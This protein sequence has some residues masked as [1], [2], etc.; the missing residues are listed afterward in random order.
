M[1]KFNLVLMSIIA[2]GLNLSLNAKPNPKSPLERTLVKSQKIAQRDALA[3][4]EAD[5]LI[6]Q[7]EFEIRNLQKRAKFHRLVTCE[8]TQ[9]AA[10]IAKLRISGKLRDG[11]KLSHQDQELSRFI[12]RT[13][14]KRFHRVK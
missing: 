8:T 9:L 11:H 12:T 3:L 2:F 1:Q 10:Q 7:R 5:Q 4:I 13:Y 14:S 6:N